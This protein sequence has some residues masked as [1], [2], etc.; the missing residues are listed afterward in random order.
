MSTPNDPSEDRPQGR[1]EHPENFGL[2]Q[3]PSYPSTPHPEDTPGYG[4]GYGGYAGYGI[5]GQPA[6]GQSQGTGVVQP[7]EAVSWAFSVVF[8]NWKLWILGALALGVVVMA[9]SAIVDMAFGGLNGDVGLQNGFG[10][11][12]AQF[13]MGLLTAALMVFVY[14]G[15]LRQVD[16]KKIGPGD[17]THD[18]NFGPAFALTIL[19]QVL[20]SLLFAALAIPLF[21][22]GNPIADTQMASDEEMLAVLG[23]LFAALAVVL[24]VAVLVSPLTMFMV[25]FVIDRRATFRGGIVEGFRHGLRNYGRLLAFNL[26]AGV[27]VGISAIITLGLAMV[28]LGPVLLL[29]QAMIYRQAAAGP[30]PEPVR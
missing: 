29:A 13:A 25:W 3:Y 2:P 1:Q 12:I 22:A 8:R 28:V 20:S 17:F 21:L 26:V 7:M 14:H 15:A 5:G 10:Y 18:V 27:I 30:L 23:T 16:K 4:A 19:L 6:Y 9:V 24:V 11:Q